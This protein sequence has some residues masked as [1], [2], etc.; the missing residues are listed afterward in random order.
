[1]EY[2]QVTYKNLKVGQKIRGTIGDG[3]SRGFTAFVKSINPAFVT[4]ELWRKGGTEEKINSSLMFEVEMTEEEFNAKYREKA[5]E[6][7]YGIQN[8]LHGDEIGYHEMWNAWL[9]GTP[10]EIAKECVKQNMR[11]IG[12]SPDI[13]PKH[14]MFSGDLLDVGVCAE[15]EDG[16]RFWCH[17]RSQ[18]IKEML[19]EYKDLIQ[20]TGGKHH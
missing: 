5:R 14:A 9:Y 13:V 7:L 6:V 18:D 12:H 17:F 2:K 4:V 15:Y 1:M 10:Y 11:V 8:R 20:E 16:E 19:E 3:C